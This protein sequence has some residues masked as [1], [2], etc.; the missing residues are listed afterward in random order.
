MKCGIWLPDYVWSRELRKKVENVMCMTERRARAT[1]G[2]HD[3]QRRMIK[4]T[5]KIYGHHP[6]EYESKQ[7][8]RATH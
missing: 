6:E 1:S 4:T 2:Q 8:Q 5:A 3:S 7:W